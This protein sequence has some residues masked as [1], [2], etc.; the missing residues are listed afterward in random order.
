VVVV[1]GSVRDGSV[2]VKRTARFDVPLEIDTEDAVA[3]GRWVAERLRE[4]GVGTH[5]AILAVPRSAVMLKRLSLPEPPDEADLPEMVRLA[6]SRQLTFPADT[7][8][9]DY[10]TPRAMK[11]GGG[12]VEVLA[13][14][15][16]GELHGWYEAVAK[17]AGLKIVRSCLRSAGLAALLGTSA[18]VASEK[19]EADER[20]ATE[21]DAVD[22][23]PTDRHLLLGMELTGREVGLVVL[24][25]G[26]LI[27]A[28]AT[29]LN[30]GAEHEH[31]EPGDAAYASLV[32][33]EARRT[34]MS[35]RVTMEAGQVDHAMLIGAPGLVEAA[36]DEVAEA[37]GV[38]VSALEAHAD[39]RCGE[40]PV[41][42]A[43]PLIGLML[44]ASRDVP[45]I[46]FAHPRKAPDRAA[47]KRQRVMLVALAVIVVLGAGYTWMKRDLAK[48]EAAF[49]RVYAK[50]RETYGKWVGLQREKARLEH[51]QRWENTRF[52]W[53]DHMLHIRD[54]LPESS[55][56]TL[57]GVSGTSSGSG[58]FYERA[59]SRR[60]NDGEWFTVTQGR[61]TIAGQAVDRDAADA[62]RSAFVDDDVYLCR[63]S[64]AD[65]QGRTNK[66]QPAKF[67]L[68]LETTAADPIEEPV[69]SPAEDGEGGAP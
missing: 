18:E 66:R 4:A 49:D 1:E 61:F 22:G 19:A 36:R 62:L 63:P 30:F 10:L 31:I 56:A 58:V 5:S 54:R 53:L 9:I 38:T 12:T 6:M 69:E 23:E 50:Q 27:F 21:S 40:T 17:A 60:Y 34:W 11:D 52:D 64:G 41:D 7:A 55:I 20:E 51:L 2:K 24:D 65:A 14:A 43:W 13:A 46:D 3:L 33:T 37:L 45:V 35:Y 59:S 42:G 67:S 44:Q 39:V 29:D 47:A 25:R 48:R 16:A 26:E 28:R 8:V 32:G 15:V 57:S 68:S